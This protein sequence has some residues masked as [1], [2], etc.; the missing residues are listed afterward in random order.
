MAANVDVFLGN[1]SIN[2]KNIRENT[3][4]CTSLITK[5]HKWYTFP[6]SFNNE[7]LTKNLV[8]SHALGKFGRDLSS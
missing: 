1:L 3:Y 6:Y 8:N 5:L 7:H 4:V 2:E